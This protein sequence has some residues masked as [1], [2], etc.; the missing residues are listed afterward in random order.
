MSRHRWWQWPRLGAQVGVRTRSVLVAVVVV[1]VALLAGGSGLVYALQ[2]N[3]EQT[4]TADASDRA[5]EVA[6]LIQSSGVTAAAASLPA[7]SRS[8]QFVQIIGHDDTVVGASNQMVGAHAMSPQRPLPDRIAAAEIDIDYLGESGDWLVVSHGVAAGPASYVVQVATPLRVQRQTLQTVSIFLLG[9]TPLLLVAV[10]VA[11]WLLVGR[12]L[13][14]VELIR[15]EVSEID[16]QR[17]ASRV[18]VP[19]TRDQIAALA[20]TMNVMLDR[21]ESSHRAQRSFVSDASHELRSPLATLTTAAELAS[22]AD[23]PTRTHL[24]NTITEELARM[25]ALV[26]NLMTL[27]RADAHDLP[28]RR[29]EVDLDD[30][31]DSEI[32]RLRA[33]STTL[34]SVELEPARVIGDPRQLEQCLRNLIDNA[35]RHAR[36][37]VRITLRTRNGEAV[38]WV[39]NDGPLIEVADRERIFERFVRLDDSRSRDVGGSGL[40]LAITRA[41]VA[42]HGGAVAVVEGPSGWCRFELRLGLPHQP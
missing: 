11:V 19:R 42:S 1:L 7:E 12:A 4:A 13:R 30:L 41:A 24:L 35:E 3:L 22:R 39:D 21:L 40:G 37:A 36:S 32:R 2:S 26:D 38:L 28:S 14:S 8:G 33:T 18:Q 9:A 31:V 16:A 17:L 25:R 23:E 10:A 29:D 20:A 15:H 34:V 27:A 6:A 5:D